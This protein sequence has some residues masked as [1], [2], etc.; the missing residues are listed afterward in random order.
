MKR[1]NIFSGDKTYISLRSA[2]HRSLQPVLR[3]VE[4]QALHICQ[5]CNP[6]NA[7]ACI[8]LILSHDVAEHAYIVR[9]HL[10]VTAQGHRSSNERL[11]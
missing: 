5:G 10:K 6:D 1:R 4:P 9:N 2:A 3:I 8:N 11:P 7:V